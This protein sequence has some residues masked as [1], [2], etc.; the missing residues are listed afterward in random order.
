MRTVRF[1]SKDLPD[2]ELHISTL[3]RVAPPG[4]HAERPFAET[5]I[6]L[7]LDNLREPLAERVL[8]ENATS[9]YMR[10]EAQK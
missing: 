9:W 6:A 8:Y 10:G 4:T 3:P 2:L 1:N 5:D 7:I